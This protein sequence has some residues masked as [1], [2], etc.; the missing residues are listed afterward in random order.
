MLQGLGMGLFSSLV[1]KY[2]VETA[3]IE[4]RGFFGAFYTMGIVV[5][6]MISS[7]QGLVI[8]PFP[9]ATDSGTLLAYR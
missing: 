7:L 6:I 8:P 1:P 2:I 9:I 3:P 5:G 4:Q